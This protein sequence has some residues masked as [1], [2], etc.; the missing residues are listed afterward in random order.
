MAESM[1]YTSADIVKAAA[2]QKPLEVKSAFDNIMVDKIAAVL[3]GKR[4]EVGATILNPQVEP[5]ETEV[6]AGAGEND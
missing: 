1:V 6:D 3:A 5:T 2:E 4:E